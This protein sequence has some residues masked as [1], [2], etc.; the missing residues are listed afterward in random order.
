MPLTRLVDTQR[1]WAKLSVDGERKARFDTLLADLQRK[2][3]NEAVAR[4]MHEALAMQVAGLSLK[5]KKAAELSTD[6]LAALATEAT[7]AQSSPVLDA[8]LAQ[9]PAASSCH[10]CHRAATLRERNAAGE[11]LLAAMPTRPAAVKRAD[12]PG[13]EERKSKRRACS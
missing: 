3:Q 7:H 1:T 9:Q 8:G 12:K 5:S 10:H 6:E 11:A 2:M 13:G 4:R